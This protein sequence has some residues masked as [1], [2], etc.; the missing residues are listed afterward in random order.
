MAVLLQHEYVS[1]TVES[2][3]SPPR[4]L[5][6]RALDSVGLL[7]LIRRHPGVRIALGERDERRCPTR[8]RP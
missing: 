7:V 2:S 4:A 6:R 8:S 5:D 1:P 3:E